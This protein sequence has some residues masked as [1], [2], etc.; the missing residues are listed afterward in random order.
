MSPPPTKRQRPDDAPAPTSITHSERLWFADGNVVLQAG[1]TQF[2][3]HWG[4]LALHSSVFRGMQ[5]LPQPPEQPSVDGCPVVEL[6][7]GTDDVECLLKALY[8]PQKTLPLAAVGA[9]I[10]LGRKYDVK[11]LLD[12]AVA[13]IGA[14]FPT[15]LSKY[16]ASYIW[17]TIEWYKGIELDAVT[18]LSENGIFTALPSAYYR[19]VDG[20]FLGNLLDGIPKDDGTRAT[21]LQADL[22]RCAVGQQ[23]I[24]LKQFEPGYTF[25]WARKWDF[26]DCPSSAVCRASRGQILNSY[27][28]AFDTWA[29]VEPRP[30]SEYNL[31]AACSQHAKESMT[32]GRKKFWQELPEIFDLPAWNE[33]KNDL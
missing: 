9:L 22:R 18:L 26:D 28:E 14:R 5:G 33:L 8:I 20:E 3:V 1:N 13:R 23:R 4:V 30:F 15:S 31:C 21:L 10:R 2:R 16:D 12:S 17:D 24:F 27:M 7:D 29:L 6:S 19:A 25:G 11:D 32:A